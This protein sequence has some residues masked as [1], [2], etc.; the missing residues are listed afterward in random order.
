[1]RFQIKWH[2]VYYHDGIE[3]A[4]SPHRTAK[5]ACDLARRQ[6]GAV[7]WSAVRVR[8]LSDGKEWTIKR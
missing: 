6:A 3:A 7:K 2:V 1:M 5:G 8:R 4:H